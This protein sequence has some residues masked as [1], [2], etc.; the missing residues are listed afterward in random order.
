MVYTC[1]DCGVFY[2]KPEFV[3]T[4]VT[5]Y[6]IKRKRVYKKLDHFKEVLSQFPGREGK[7]VTGEVLRKIRSDLADNVCSGVTVEDVKKA[8]GG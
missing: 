2:D 8:C 6:L 1:A 7:I 5:N 4:D 3:V